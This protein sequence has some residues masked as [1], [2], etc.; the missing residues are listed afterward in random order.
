MKLHA[1]NRSRSS[2]KSTGFFKGSSMTEACRTQGQFVRDMQ[3]FELRKQ[4]N[5][6][7]LRRT[8]QNEFSETMKDA[9]DNVSMKSKRSFSAVSR[10]SIKQIRKDIASKSQERQ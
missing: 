6:D 7:K 8:L 2:M 5:I 4:G 10:K 1:N 3:T 9:F